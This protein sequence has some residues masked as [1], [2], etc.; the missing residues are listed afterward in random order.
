MEKP[1]LVV[2]ESPAK[3][4]TIAKY[5]G[6]GY[7]VEATRGHIMDLAKSPTI[8]LGVD[9]ENDF[10]PKYEVISD[11]KDTVKAIK[12]SAVNASQIL[13]AADPDREG[14]AI[15]WHVAGLLHKSKVDIKRVLFKEI[16]KDAVKKGVDNP[17]KLNKNLYDAQQARRVLDRLVGFLVSPILWKTYNSKCS[18]GRVQSVCLKLITER[19]NEILNFKPETYFNIT[20][21]IIKN[22]DKI[23]AKYTD[24]L[25]DET[26]AKSIKKDLDQS[27]Y[28]ITNIEEKPLN[29]N[30]P[31]PLTTSKMQQVASA[32]FKM[33]ASKTMQTAQQLYESGAVSYIR[34]DSTRSSPES[35]QAVRDYLAKNKL[36]VPKQ[37]NYFKNKS[38]A[39]DAHEAIRPTNIDLKPS[40]FDGTPEQKKLYQ[41]IWE[42]F[43][44]SQM[45][46]AIYDTVA[47]T[48]ESSIN[49]HKLK[50][51][52]RTLKYAGWLE[53]LSSFDDKEEEI[54]LPKVNQ[55]DIFTLTPPKVVLEKKETQPPPRFNE[56]SLIKELEKRGIGRPSTYATIIGKISER[57]YVVKDK[58]NFKPTELGSQ[59]VETLDKHFTFMNFNYT[60]QMEDKLDKIEEGELEYVKMMTEFY[61][62]F[63][64]E[65]GSAKTS[66]SMVLSTTCKKCGGNLEVLNGK[67]GEWAKC[68]MGCTKGSVILEGGER[69]LVVKANQIS[70]DVRCPQCKAPMIMRTGRFGDFYACS[71]YPLCK[72]TKPIPV[73]KKCP[74]CNEDLYYR[75][76]G[77]NQHL[78]CTGYPGCKYKEK[79]EVRVVDATSNKNIDTLE[80]VVG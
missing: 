29:K 56:G 65:I 25:T 47:I 50:A 24:K 59:V 19:E 75:M 57:L 72:K 70:E 63:K 34:T 64:T 3:A 69:R 61:D 35:I 71:T 32:R 9:I 67:F 33:A 53:I 22:K 26:K 10:T 52:G 73:D 38:G 44:A 2:V 28:K 43:V 36:D 23:I 30:A 55:N 62:L 79:T 17:I 18:A 12:A 4:K 5:L 80:K 76:L 8:P 77:T 42:F 58:N 37:P 11:K 6:K 41:I 45:N 66:V 48:F 27:D 13:I 15:A 60:A 54:T 51:N 20:A 21:N 31:P 40:Q 68:P 74:E 39:Q 49:K 78:C 7:I 16:T 1:I 14:E 46:P